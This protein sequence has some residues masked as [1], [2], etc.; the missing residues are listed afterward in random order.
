MTTS[1]LGRVYQWLEVGRGKVLLTMK[2]IKKV[3][4]GIL[5]QEN[6]MKGPADF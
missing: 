3:D 5:A 6:M 4:L 1:R 2:G